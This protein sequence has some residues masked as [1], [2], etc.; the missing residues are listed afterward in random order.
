MAVEA[1]NGNRRALIVKMGAIGDVIMVLPAARALHDLGYE[2][3]WLCGGLVE[4][5]LRLYPWI[6]PHMADEAAILR[7]SAAARLRAM[8]SVWRDLGRASFDSVFTLYFDRRYDLLTLPVRAR[9]KLRLT[10]EDRGSGLVP[11]RSY[12]DEYVRL[13][14]AREDGEWPAH[15]APLPPAE[16]P[17]SPVPRAEG[18]RRIVLVPGGARN[19]LRDDAL[20]RWPVENY[21]AVA[22]ERLGRGDEVVLLG[23]PTDTWV[24]PAFDGLAVTNCIGRFSLVESLALLDSADVTVTHDTGPLHLAGVART[25]IVAIF[26][27]TSPHTFQPQRPNSLALWG[28]EGFACRPCY[29]GRNFAPCTHNGCVEQITP[30]FAGQCVDRLLEARE[31]GEALP[32]R[33]LTV[34]DREHPLVQIA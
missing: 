12:A 24:L 3:H 28:G 31:R 22:R 30:A 33:V 6:H 11:G 29:D 21:V 10:R 23:G 2:V 20:R 25:G 26:G 17:A 34:R 13:V 9:R 4:P 8:T 16:M 27:P 32:A 5:L 19:L 14:T 15:T 18:R 1:A 7:G